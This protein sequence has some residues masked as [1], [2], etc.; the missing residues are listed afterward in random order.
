M[1]PKEEPLKEKDVK[2]GR[3]KR[4]RW[5]WGKIGGREEISGKTISDK[6]DER[7]VRDEEETGK[8]Y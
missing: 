1:W 4:R 3:K 5:E 6:T 7:W 2:N 8:N